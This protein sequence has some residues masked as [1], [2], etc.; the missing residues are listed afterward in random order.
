M[1]STRAYEIF[2]QLKIVSNNPYVFINLGGVHSKMGNT[3]SSHGAIL[4]WLL[5]SAGTSNIRY[6]I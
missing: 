4:I 3:P 6:L 1:Y 2:T 5:I